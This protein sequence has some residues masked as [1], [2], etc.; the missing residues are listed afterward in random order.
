MSSTTM[1]GGFSGSAESVDTTKAR[2]TLVKAIGMLASLK[3]TI[4]LFV[5]AMFI[6]LIGSLAQS[7]RDVWMVMAQYFRTYLAMVDVAD[8]FPPSMFPSLADFNWDSLPIRRFPFPGG[9]LIGWVMLANLLAAHFLK[10]R[11]QARGMRLISGLAIITIG[12][13]L[14]SAVII[15][16]N[17]QT[18][19]ESGSLAFSPDQI[20]SMLLAVLGLTAVI[21][22]GI[23]A[24]GRSESR[25]ARVVLALMG[26]AM[27]GVLLYFVIGGESARLN[28]SSM[29]IL[30]Q[31]LKGGACSL[32]LLI[33]CHLVFEKRGGIVLLHAGVALLMFSE[34]QVGIYGKENQLMLIEGQKSSFMRDI[35]EREL[36]ISQRGE[37]GQDHFVV[38]PQALLENAVRQTDPAKQVIELKDLPFDVA[39]RRFYLNSSLRGILPDDSVKTTD[40]LGSFAAAV[41]LAPVTGMDSTSDVSSIYVDL[42]ERGSGKV[43]SSHLLSQNV[44]E[45]RQVPIAEPVR[46]ADKDYQL[47]LRFQRNYRPYEVELLDVS[48]TNYVGSSTP[49]D[50]RSRIVIRDPAQKTSEEFTLWMNNPLRYHG[51]TFYQSSY[52]KLE[53]G[54]EAT[55]L[56]VVRN[57]GW[58][59]PYIAC[60][61]VSFGMFGQFWQT[62]S[63]YLKREE[64]LV[65]PQA[66]GV[67]TE[68]VANLEQ[69]ATGQLPAALRRPA[70]ELPAEVAPWQSSESPASA[71]AAVTTGGSSGPDGWSMRSVL[72][73]AI[74]VLLFAVYLLRGVRVPQESSDA[75]N[76]FSFA[77]VPIAWSGRAQPIDSFARTQLLMTSHKSTFEGELDRIELDAQRDKIL[78]AFSK[79]WPEVKADRLNSFSGTYQEW[80]AEMMR[81]TTSSEEAVEE[82]MRSVLVRRMPAVRWFLD[83]AARPE[84]VVRHR[85]IKIDDDQLLASLSLPKRP[86]LTYS[87]DDIQTRLK[88]LEPVHQEALTLQRNKEDH[89]LT[90]QQRRVLALFETISR[91]AQIREKFLIEN[92]QPFA[93]TL[94]T[95]WRILRQLGDQPG[96]MGIPTGSEDEQR[97]WESVVAANVLLQL[98]RQ[99]KQNEILSE[100]QLR[101]YVSTKLPEVMA[102]S[103]PESID[104]TMQIISSAVEKD[105]NGMADPTAIRQRAQAAADGMKDRDPYLS[106]LLSIIAKSPAE[107]TA[108]E[109]AAGVSKEKQIELASTKISS[110]LFEVLTTIDSESPG[111]SRLNEIRKRMLSQGTGDALQ[112]AKAMNPEL[113]VLAYQDLQP[114]AGHLLYGGDNADTFEKNAGSVIGILTAWQNTD[115]AAFNKGVSEYRALLT[116]EKIPHL[117]SR[118]V[119]TEAWFN[120]F[121]PFYKATLLYLPILVL[122]FF[123]W[124]IPGPTIR[125]TAFSL[126]LLA[127]VIHTAALLLRMWISGRPPVTNLYS[128][129][130]F[131]GWAVVLAAFAVELILKNG[132]GNILGA[133]TGAA[134]LT[135]AHYLARDEGDTLGVMQAV[136]DTQFWLATHVVCI[137]LGYA[138]TFLAGG[139]GI[140][141][142]VMAAFQRSAKVAGNLKSVGALVYGVL[143][144]ALFFSLV[145]TVLGGLWADDSW[146]RF[147]GW[148]PKENGAMLIVLWNAV[149]LHARWDKMIRDY[150]TSVLAIFGNIV[151]AW[152]WFGVNELKAGLHTYGFTEGRLFAL[153]M[154][155]AIQLGVIVVAL[156]VRRVLSQKLSQS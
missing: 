113:A 13:V 58:M 131:I 33:G 6:V 105:E 12:V 17:S 93:E 53:D 26:V 55:T 100:E 91:I 89:K 42:I 73:P 64:R 95:S 20:W 54:T 72:I 40:G 75:M 112:L 44:S 90:T 119:A 86:G 36:A 16:G 127:F 143:C 78:K 125:R 27:S 84:M 14:T 147:W 128:S 8:L 3:L 87:L 101:E 4:V 76:L 38:I 5:L 51:E 117:N 82:R 61:I 18:G 132:I 145:G 118:V 1:P 154:F 11:I 43:L 104:R 156:V 79:A 28:V 67:A 46:V 88:D 130:I 52:N 32:V 124:I 114:R 109:I 9:W 126:M 25:M 98:S 80:I 56:S 83:L 34:L 102:A 60:M 122:S 115:V 57:K 144:F 141:Y 146:G 121:E 153:A 31:L 7:R 85:V 65:T 68:A 149:I 120:Y 103:I 29:R 23:A 148:D 110:V 142:C 150:G 2:Q 139:I 35:R 69:S 96:V 94:V 47:Y 107:Q 19:V 133:S 134:T 116:K 70:V 74:T 50:Y 66:V 22:F 21:C 15:T 138:A 49:R 48:R 71:D 97:S 152:S 92:E 10:F 140:V 37:D 129:A 77:Q 59:L 137:T 135:I 39:V 99:L 108:A 62:L 111:D 136:L 151:T 24:A 45:L 41:E 81:L 106:E 123:G 30:W 63:R 155:V